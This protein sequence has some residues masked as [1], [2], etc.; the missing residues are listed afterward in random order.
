LDAEAEAIFPHFDKN[1]RNIGLGDNESTA[2]LIVPLNMIIV[3]A[4]CY[5]EL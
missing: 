4:C 5:N 1:K 3:E 2:P